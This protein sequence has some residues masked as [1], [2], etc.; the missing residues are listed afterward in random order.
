MTTGDVVAVMTAVP[1]IL[2]AFAALVAAF[3]HQ[4]DIAGV[5]V[6]QD[7]LRS[8]NVALAATNSQLAAQVAAKTGEMAGRDFTTAAAQIPPAQVGK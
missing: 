3:K 2:L 6:A 4:G 1:A 7:G 5:K 8:D